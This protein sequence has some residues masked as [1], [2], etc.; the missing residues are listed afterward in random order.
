VTLLVAGTP[1]VATGG[2]GPPSAPQPVTAFHVTGFASGVLTLS[3]SSGPAGT[4]VT[5]SGTGFAASSPI[6]FTLDGRSAPAAC[7]TDATGDFPGTTGTP[8]TFLVPIAPLGNQTVVAVAA[9]SSAAISV[10]TQPYGVAYDARL[11]EVYISASASDDVRVITDS[12]DS[13]ARTVG[14]GSTSPWAIGDD[15]A[16]GE[17]FVTSYY[18]NNVT[19]IND[20]N[21]SIVTSVDVGSGPYDI[22]D[23]AVLGEMFVSN[24]GSNTLSVISDTT[25]T[26]V[27]TVGVG[28]SPDREAYDATRGEVFVTNSLSNNVSVVNTSSD[29][30]VASVPVGSN[31]VGIA[32]DAAIG[33]MFVS[34]Y[35]SND[36]SVINDTTDSVVATIG[37]G[38]DPTGV[39]YDPAQG[40]MVVANAGS[41][42]LSLVSVATDSVAGGLPIGD[43]PQVIAYDSGEDSLFISNYLSANASVVNFSVPVA[44]TF[45]VNAS[46]TLTLSPMAGI[47]GT[48]VTANGSN[49]EPNA[50]ITFRIDGTAATSSCSTDANG[51]FP[52]GS[53]TSCTFRVPSPRPGGTVI[54][55]ASDGKAAATAP[56]TIRPGLTLSP[57]SGHLGGSVTANGTG[58]AASASI[59]FSVGGAGRLS[60]C[61]TDSTGSFPGAT[62]TPCRFTVPTVPGGNETVVASD[63]TVNVSGSEVGGYPFG[64]AVD[65]GR[66]EAFI[67]TSMG[68]ALT[69]L[70]SSN[71]TF[72]RTVPLVSTAPWAI[73]YDPI[74][75]EMYVTAYFQN[76]VS[77]V[78]LTTDAA[79]AT[80]GVGTGPYGIAYDSGLGEMFVANSG[81]NNVSVISDAT[82]TVVGTEDVARSPYAVAYDAGQGT[83]FVSDS[84]S[85]S[86]SEFSD[87]L[88]SPVLTIGVGTNPAGIAYDPLLGEVFVANYL[89]NNVTVIND[90]TDAIA[91]WIG[92]G[93][94]P[95]GVGYDPDDGDVFVANAGSG[96]V[97]MISP[98]NDTVVGSFGVGSAPEVVA[99]DPASGRLFVTNYFSSNASAV[100]FP[101]RATAAFIVNTSLSL[102][103]TTGQVDAGQTVTVEGAGFGR[104][105]AITTFTIGSSSLNCTGATV[106][107]CVGGTLISA[108]D[109]S[110]V[111]TFAVPANTTPGAY[112]VS[113]GD[114]AGN[115]GV[116]SIVVDADPSVTIPHASSATSDVGQS[117]TFST[118]A[119]LGSGGYTYAWSG[120][121]AG[122]TGTLASIACTPHTAGIFNISVR[123]TDSSGFSVVSGTLAFTVLPD[124]TVALPKPSVLSGGVDAGQSVTFT[125]TA[126]LGTT[127]YLSF[128]W[129]GLPVGCVGSSESVTCS[130]ANLATG[131]YGI[132]AEVTDSN[133]FTSAASP[134]L[135]FFVDNDPE[136]ST[137]V[138]SVASADVGQSFTI[139]VTASL[140]SG[141]YSFAWAGLPSGCTPA[142]TYEAT[143]RPT[144]SG[145]ILLN[146]T[147]TDANDFGV[148][149]PVFTMAIHP[150]PSVTLSADRLAVDAREPVV[151]TAHPSGGSAGYRYAW[152]GFPIGC[153]GNSASITCVPPKPGS[154]TLAV[155]VTDSNGV[156]A[157]SPGALL[158]VA[159]PPSANFS[160]APGL[161]SPGQIVVFNANANGG[162]GAINYTWAFGDGTAG[163]GDTVGHAYRVAGY[164]TVTLWVNDSTGWSS[165]ET[166]NLTVGTPAKASS[167]WTGLDTLVAI[168][169][170]AL[171]V[172]VVLV[173]LY[174]GDRL[175]RRPETP[176]EDG[177]PTEESTSVAPA[178]VETDPAQGPPT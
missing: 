139:S 43:A 126:S 80:I 171:L 32:F 68:N 177:A 58:Y 167:G 62:G 33:E 72:A 31:P 147:V 63:T 9:N 172:A 56:F 75:D 60:T 22:V 23:D 133:N 165:S 91:G 164:F 30:T 49:F 39:T 48:L 26:V 44:S 54:V 135:S 40:V 104:S 16:R 153:G 174:R 163:S 175:R 176:T 37:V 140:G 85:Y 142:P 4:K 97:S 141:P 159:A 122:C 168:V 70:Y 161:P 169:G 61:S 47:L 131:L 112:L 92:V 53:G 57:D 138:A 173:I 19:V 137:P 136:V 129:L 24:S 162:T 81:S 108:S 51:S 77:V 14:F 88:S 95:A 65:P 134:V 154:F 71:G 42:S 115:A 34:N 21:N 107:T 59:S 13:I 10:G 45:Q 55:S 100:G 25:N 38:T 103:P 67:A 117:V 148:T 118:T 28:T 74:Y 105:L 170:I 73:A 29:T 78:N 101:D 146:V 157:T 66:G 114:T 111:A 158:I 46:P 5:A 82:N 155:V 41:D 143:C 156:S 132:S 52:G 3:P 36:V 121:P 84:A 7:R 123:A 89:S 178:S 120:L 151:V 124:P 128:M 83:V 119:T 6:E 2:A 15:P 150:D 79:V 166:L 130:G 11:G 94:E 109:G 110:V 106:G 90:S 96:N 145:E 17:M 144:A 18:S 64:V 116:A 93:T 125:A 27:A 50:M 1:S 76:Y 102:L 149:S 35:L 127:D 12:N 86:V 87:T 20:T 113:L 69:V 8:C 98:S 99:A 160:A 152:T